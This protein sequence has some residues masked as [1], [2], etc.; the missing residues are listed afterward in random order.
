MVWRPERTISTGDDDRLA[1]RRRFDGE[2]AFLKGST[3][4]LIFR[5][6][7]GFDWLTYPSLVNDTRTL[8]RRIFLAQ[9]VT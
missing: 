9:G 7:D 1:G 8:P 6:R 3:D 2:L 5:D 4:G